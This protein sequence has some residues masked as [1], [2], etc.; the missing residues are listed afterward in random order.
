MPITIYH[1]PRCSKSRETLALIEAAGH[2]PRVIRYLETGWQPEQLEAL[3]SAAGLS[4]RDALRCGEPEAKT[5]PADASEAQI[6]A[7]MVASP[8]LVNR[9]I[10]SSEAGTLLCRPPERVLEILP[11]TKERGEAS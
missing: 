5:I 1:N 4:A 11:P 3:L 8:K 9:P 7:A 6:I 2:A 10:V